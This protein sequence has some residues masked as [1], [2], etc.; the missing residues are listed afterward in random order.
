MTN[1]I[2]KGTTKYQKSNKNKEQEK[3]DY[4][5]IGL[6]FSFYLISVIL[7]SMTFF[8][9]RDL[10][11][12]E[13]SRFAAASFAFLTGSRSNKGIDE[14][15]PPSREAFDKR[16]IVNGNIVTEIPHDGLST[17]DIFGSDTELSDCKESNHLHES[18]H[19]LPIEEVVVIQSETSNA[20]PIE[21]KKL[22]LSHQN[23]TNKREETSNALPIEEVVVIQSETSNA[24]PI[25][26][27]SSDALPRK[28]SRN[29]LSQMHYNRRSADQMHQ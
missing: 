7:A 10:K 23:T 12:S 24:L 3:Q 22:K 27:E 4:I 29:N 14:D 11:K 25:E 20:L 6:G 18:T 5:I 19:A 21:E 1:E 2:T 15:R 13:E 9:T 26:E 17:T 28:S 16:K 8:W